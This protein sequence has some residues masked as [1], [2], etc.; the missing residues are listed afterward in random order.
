MLALRRVRTVIIGTENK[1]APWLASPATVA[2]I[3]IARQQLSFAEL[4]AQH[5]VGMAQV[6][7]VHALVEGAPRVA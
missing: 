4:Q 7:G 6:G 3:A 2:A 1:G 5:D